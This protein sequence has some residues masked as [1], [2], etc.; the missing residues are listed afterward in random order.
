MLNVGL[1]GGIGCGKSTVARMLTRKGAFVIDFD[2]VAHEVQEP[3]ATAWKAVVAEFGPGVLRPDRT[4]DR[5]KLGAIVFNDAAKRHRLNEIVHPAVFEE[6]RT[7]RDAICREKPD[8]VVIAD[9]PL[10]F[11]VRMQAMLDLVLLV[12][13]GPE[14]QIRRIMKRNGYTR[15]E[16]SLRLASQ[17]PIDEKVPLADFV[18]NN[19][20]T[21][22]ETEAQ[23][24]DIWR[25]LTEIEKEKRLGSAA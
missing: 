6:W 8:A 16:A 18:I 22:G 14:G 13:L 11:E 24:E 20:G 1:T 17:M 4:L 12:Y 15:E 25:K 9:V 7:R 5:D 23:V 21:F 2:R 3:D 19:E 10:L